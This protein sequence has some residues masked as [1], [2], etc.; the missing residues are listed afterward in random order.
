MA[1]LKRLNAPRFWRIPRVKKKFVLAVGPGS[2]PMKR[3]YPL[4]VVLR[5]ILKFARNL[6]EVKFI[7][8]SRLIELNGRVITNP[9]FPVGLSDIIYVKKEEK[10]FIV[11]PTPNGFEFREISKD[12]ASQK[13]EKVVNKTKIKNGKIQITFHDGENKIVDDESIKI[14]DTIIL[15]TN[16][17][18]IKKRLEYKEGAYVIITSGE[19]AG[20]IGKIDKIEIV[21][22]SM[23]NTVTIDIK[24]NKIKS[25]PKNLFVIEKSIEFL[26]VK[27]NE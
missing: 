24:G 3:S 7:L 1:I 21:H 27:P 8:N 14:N 6:K 15:N 17:K 20:E 26:K 9:N 11:L 4:G 22:S 18:E 25:V 5:D 13:L 10:Y 2:H 16:T 23:P 19:R 12:S